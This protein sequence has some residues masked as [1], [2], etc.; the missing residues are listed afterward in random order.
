M[1]A[2]IDSG[3]RRGCSQCRAFVERGNT[4]MYIT[5]ANSAAGSRHLFI[6]T[7]S[8]TSTAW[9]SPR[10]SDAKYSASNA[11]AST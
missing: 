3:V 4:P 5:T 10:E 8:A 7:S 6:V 9:G 2:T 1:H 11:T